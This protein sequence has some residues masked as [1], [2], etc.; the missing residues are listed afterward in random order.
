M[1]Q[2]LIFRH[3]LV[4]VLEIEAASEDFGAT[5]HAATPCEVGCGGLLC[6]FALRLRSL[7][8]EAYR[9]GLYDILLATHCVRACL[10]AKPRS[11]EAFSPHL[12]LLSTRGRDSCLWRKWFEKLLEEVQ[13]RAGQESCC[14][15]GALSSLS[16]SLSLSLFLC[17]GEGA[18]EA[19]G[20][21]L[22]TD[23]EAQEIPS[24]GLNVSPVSDVRCTSL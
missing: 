15:A 13:A 10:A 22:H 11:G 2:Q 16:R 14:E 17:P 3:A 7:R 5:L 9:V 20:G 24:P 6:A 18:T 12:R 23:H 4:E 1:P 21:P 19:T 8:V